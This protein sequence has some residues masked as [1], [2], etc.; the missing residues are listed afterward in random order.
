[1]HEITASELRSSIRDAAKM[2]D[3]LGMR[4]VVKRRGRPSFAIVPLED[5]EILYE[6][7]RH[8]SRHQ[9][10]RALQM[11]LKVNFDIEEIDHG[12]D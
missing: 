5:L 7:D 9:I 1:M 4:T 12:S 11:G 8:Y 2:T 3:H 10:Y 6:I